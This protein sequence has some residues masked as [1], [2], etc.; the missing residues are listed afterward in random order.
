MVWWRWQLA[1]I[2]DYGFGKKV[3][4]RAKNWSTI[5]EGGLKVGTIGR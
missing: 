3:M 5:E 2:M 1:T 4:G